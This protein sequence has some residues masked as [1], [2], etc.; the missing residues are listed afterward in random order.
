MMQQ[1]IVCRKK[2]KGRDQNYPYKVIEVTPPPKSLG[3][4]CFPPVSINHPQF[5]FYNSTIYSFCQY[6]QNKGKLF[7]L[8]ISKIDFRE[9]FFVIMGNVAIDFVSKNYRF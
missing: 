4:R 9:H 1:Q 8:P 7:D 3:V 2:E 6:L 5:Q